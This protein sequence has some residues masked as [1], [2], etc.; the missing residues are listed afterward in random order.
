MCHFQSD[1]PVAVHDLLADIQ[2]GR[3]LM[4]LLEQLS[5]CKLVR[6]A[7]CSGT[8][9]CHQQMKTLFS[10]IFACLFDSVA[11]HNNCGIHQTNLN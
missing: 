6:A 4:A 9:G 5:G 3:V 11:L 10:F 2:D 1:P 7:S 8:I